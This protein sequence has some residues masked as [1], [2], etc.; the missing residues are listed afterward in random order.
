MKEKK[1]KILPFSREVW[2]AEGDEFKI[3]VDRILKAHPVKNLT[4]DEVVTTL[5][6]LEL[7]AALDE[8]GDGTYVYINTNDERLEMCDDYDKFLAMLIDVE[9]REKILTTKRC[10]SFFGGTVY[11]W[12]K[13]AHKCPITSVAT[14]FSEESSGYF[15]RG[16]IVAPHIETLRRWILK[17]SEYSKIQKLKI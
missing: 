3:E 9:L 4:E 8:Y 12:R 2:M 1:I 15:G 16:W 6:M 13:I 5:R 14:A 17:N 11:Y 7:Q 10:R